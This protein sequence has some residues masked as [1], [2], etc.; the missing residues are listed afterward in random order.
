M[1]RYKIKE[2]EFERILRDMYYDRDICEFLGLEYTNIGEEDIRKI[3][4]Y[5]LE[6]CEIIR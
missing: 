1:E 6:I 3:D 5:L 2:E 4:K